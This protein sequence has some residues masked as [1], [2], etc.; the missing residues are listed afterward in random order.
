MVENNDSMRQEEHVIEDTPFNNDCV[1]SVGNNLAD[2][3]QTSVA[4]SI[5]QPV[6]DYGE[7][8]D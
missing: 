6:I 4:Q 7:V 2:Y 3:G 8:Q 1:Q 5:E